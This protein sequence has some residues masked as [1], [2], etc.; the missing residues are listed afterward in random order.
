MALSIESISMVDKGRNVNEH[1]LTPV[2][3]VVSIDV[4]MRTII[5]PGH[6]GSCEQLIRPTDL[7]KKKEAGSSF[8]CLEKEGKES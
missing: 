2:P 3:V 6:C 5:S 7:K 8:Y 4:R 1:N